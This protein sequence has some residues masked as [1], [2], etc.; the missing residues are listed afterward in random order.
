MTDKFIKNLDDLINKANEIVRSIY[1]QLP[2]FIKILCIDDSHHDC[3]LLKNILSLQGKVIYE[4][5]CVD[6]SNDGLEKILEKK[7]DIYLVDFKITPF[8]GISL[9]KKANEMGVYGPFVI[10]SGYNNHEFYEEALKEEIVGFIPKEMIVASA[11]NA[12]V[13][14]DNLIR[15]SLKNYRIGRS[16]VDFIAAYN[17]YNNPS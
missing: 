8:D 6:N 17:K 7:H 10:F 1:Y 4:V 5:E 13:V 14:I 2:H 15:L 12:Y 16:S 3:E 11:S 9:I